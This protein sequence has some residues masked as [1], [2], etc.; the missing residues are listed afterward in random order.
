MADA[1]AA[2]TDADP[3]SVGQYLKDAGVAERMMGMAEAGYANTGG[4]KLSKLSLAY[5][6][7]NER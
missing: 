7:M 4:S 1:D 2:T 3:R 6:C 5:Q